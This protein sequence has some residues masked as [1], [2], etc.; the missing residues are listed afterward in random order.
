MKKSEKNVSLS[1]GEVVRLRS[2]GP[3]MCVKEIAGGNVRCVWFNSEGVPCEHVF[4]EYQ[5]GTPTSIS[6]ILQLPSGGPYMTR[7]GDG[8]KDGTALCAWFDKDGKICERE[9]P[10]TSLANVGG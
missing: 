2:G 4:H 7:V 10:T 8:Q 3:V 6:H 5:L 9:F 1:K